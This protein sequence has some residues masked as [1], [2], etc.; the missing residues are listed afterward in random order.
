M[1]AKTK[2]SSKNK[3]K[4]KARI[5]R[6]SG[7]YWPGPTRLYDPD[8]GCGAVLLTIEQAHSAVLAI[9]TAFRS[10]E[11]DDATMGRLVQVATILDHTFRLNIGLEPLPAGTSVTWC[12][13]PWEVVEWQPHNGFGGCYHLKNSAGQSATATPDEITAD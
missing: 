9:A 7:Y 13:E 6:N 8:V 11:H 5:A 1:A 12:G 3:P 2:G 10:G 4:C